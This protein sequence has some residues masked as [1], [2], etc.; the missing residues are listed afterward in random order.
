MSRDSLLY[1]CA[2]QAEGKDDT[3]QVVK[4]YRLNRFEILSLKLQHFNSSTAITQS[5]ME[6]DRIAL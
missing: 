2:V 4:P 6:V 1:K 5:N 3:T